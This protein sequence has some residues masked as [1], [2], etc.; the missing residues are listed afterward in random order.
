M[1][2]PR[3]QDRMWHDVGIPAETIE[4]RH[5]V[6]RVVEERVAPHA[7]EI[8]QREESVDSFPW[9]A[10]RGLTDA[11]IFALPFATDFGRGLQYPLH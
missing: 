9:E 5:E 8:G 1:T 11:G 6:R 4:L 10:F 2:V 3:T 7:R